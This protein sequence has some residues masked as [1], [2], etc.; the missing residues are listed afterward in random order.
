MLKY[1]HVTVPYY[2]PIALASAFLGLTTSGGFLNFNFILPFIA[3]ALLVAA[4]NTFNGVTDF[5]IDL[6]NKP[7][8][9]IPAG[10]MTRKQA[11]VYSMILYIISFYIAYNVNTQFFQIILL[12]AILTISYSL[13]YIRIRKRLFFSNLSGAVFYGILCPLA[14]WSIFPSNPIPVYFIGFTFILAFSLSITKDMEDVIGDRAY[15][16]NTMPVFLGMKDAAWIT[17]V[18]LTVSFAYLLLA[19]LLGLI[20]NSFLIS[21][22]AFPPFVYLIREFYKNGGNPH[23]TL[24]D[25]TTAKKLFY[26]LIGL[27]ILLELV[28]SITA[29]L[30]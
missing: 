6:I 7:H 13:P 27:G 24:E 26:L 14:G 18:I 2:I 20:E 10:K 4:F 1:I 3:L 21:L 8:R 28:I 17:A 5:K 16:V 9:P 25:K 19:I 11:S 22:I 29:L 30:A 23:F 12:S 15:S